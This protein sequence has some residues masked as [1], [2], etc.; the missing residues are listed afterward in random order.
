MTT[1]LTTAQTTHWV[2]DPVHTMVEFKVRH[3][4][5]ANVRGRFPKVDATIHE[6]EDAADTRVDVEIDASSVDTQ[7][8]KRDE[9]LRSADFFDVEKHPTITFRST[10]IEP[11]GNGRFEVTGDLTIRGVTKQ[12]VLEVKEEGQTKDPWGGE[13]MGFSATGTV[14]R[15]DFGLKW[16]V[17]LEA[18]GVMVGD[19]VQIRI[20]AEAVKQAD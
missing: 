5:I 18:G 19:I 7:D 20:E 1:G 12:V 11:K 8:P 15:K 10:K 14:N 16:N 4:M 3:L 13:R 17:A 6:A 9:H 2:I